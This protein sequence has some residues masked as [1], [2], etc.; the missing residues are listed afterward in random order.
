M[1]ISATDGFLS[2]IWVY[3]GII[4]NAP[5]LGNSNLFH[6]RLNALVHDYLSASGIRLIAKVPIR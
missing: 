4:W 6:F 5:P 3:L 2:I 1:G